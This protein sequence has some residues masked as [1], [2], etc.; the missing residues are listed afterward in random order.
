MGVRVA[1]PETAGGAWRRLPPWPSRGPRRD[2]RCV[3]AA[4]TAHCITVKRVA[5][6]LRCT[7]RKRGAAPTILSILPVRGTRA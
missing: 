3:A 4:G 6:G 5:G 2:A 1:T 7:V